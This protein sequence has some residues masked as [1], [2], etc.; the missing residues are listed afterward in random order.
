MTKPEPMDDMQQNCFRLFVEMGAKR[1]LPKLA[2]VVR[3]QGLNV[4][5]RMLRRWS[6]KYRWAEEASKTA[7]IVAQKTEAVLL[8]DSVARARVVVGNLRSLQDRFIKRLA[9]DPNDPT[10]T[11]AQKARAIDPDF[12]DFQEAVKLER[13]ILGDP[14]ERRED[15]TVSRIQIELGESELLSVA[16]EL[17]QKRYGLPSAEDIKNITDNARESD[18]VQ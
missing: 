1:S 3:E 18:I 10:L 11:E 15:V 12:R 7:A 4:T 13:L 9:L 5:E 6:T 16:R 8:E 2:A 14:T 17:A